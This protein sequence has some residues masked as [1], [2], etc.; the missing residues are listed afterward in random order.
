MEARRSAATVAVLDVIEEEQ[1][2]GPTG[3]IGC[4]E[5]PTTRPVASQVRLKRV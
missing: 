3:V 5:A 1:L 4:E 2:L